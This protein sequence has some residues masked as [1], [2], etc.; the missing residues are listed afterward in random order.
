MDFLRKLICFF[1]FSYSIF[2]YDDYY[3]DDNDYEEVQV[4]KKKKPNSRRNKRKGNRKQRSG[5]IHTI[6]DKTH[7]CVDATLFNFSNLKEI[8]LF[9]DITKLDDAIKNENNVLTWVCPTLFLGY[10][11]NNS[12]GISLKIGAA[13]TLQTQIERYKFKLGVVFRYNLNLFLSLR[14]LF[15]AGLGYCFVTKEDNRMFKV[16]NG[17]SLVNKNLSSFFNTKIDPLIVCANIGVG[18]L[19]LSVHLGGEISFSRLFSEYNGDSVNNKYQNVLSQYLDRKWSN[20]VIDVF[21]ISMRFYPL[22]LV[23]YIIGWLI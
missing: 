22:K 21:N 2:A 10:N 16:S 6:T 15:E 17:G 20:Y 11:F 1:S 4:I 9:T 23:D 19:F 13:N 7:I 12:K 5:I 14:L 18:F 3:D 8:S